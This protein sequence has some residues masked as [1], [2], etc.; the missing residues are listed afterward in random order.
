MGL[1]LYRKRLICKLLII[2][3]LNIADWLCTWILLHTGAFA[4]MNPLVGSF[5]GSPT[6]G[7][8][9][10]GILPAVLLTLVCLMNQ[11]LG[12]KELM[13]VDRFASFTTMLYTA[14]CTVHIINFLLLHFAG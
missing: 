7:F 6:A 3:A 8:F 12:E 13:Q 11:L 2:Y 4:E 10:K 5:I 14:L 1:I 9:V